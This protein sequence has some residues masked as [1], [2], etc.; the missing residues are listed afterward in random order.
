MAEK[1]NPSTP[2][3]LA[4]LAASMDDPLKGRF[5]MDVPTLNLIGEIALGDRDEGEFTPKELAKAFHAHL[6]RVF[7]NQVCDE[8]A[9]RKNMAGVLET[10]LLISSVD[11]QASRA[12]PGFVCIGTLYMK[13]TVNDHVVKF[14]FKRHPLLLEIYSH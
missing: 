9:D 7:S 5:H 2:I 11:G 4:K 10:N 13:R 14:A 12:V 8:R 1:Q 6:E 3:A